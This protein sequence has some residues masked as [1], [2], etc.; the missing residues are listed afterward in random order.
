M[1]RRH[2][3]IGYWSL[4][5]GHL[6]VWQFPPLRLKDQDKK[7]VKNDKDRKPDKDEKTALERL[8]PSPVH[9]QSKKQRQ[10]TNDRHR[11]A[12]ED[13][14]HVRELNEFNSPIAHRKN[15]NSI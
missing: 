9:P 11:T 5:I 3:T 2:T 15:Y 8:L 1:C 13:R 6:S 14:A 12:F 7:P 10:K 4:D